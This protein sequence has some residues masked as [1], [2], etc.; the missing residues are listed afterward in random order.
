MTPL[1]WRN[2]F[3]PID[4]VSSPTSAPRHPAARSSSYIATC[5]ANV[6][7]LFRQTRRKVEIKRSLF[8]GCQDEMRVQLCVELYCALCVCLDIVKHITGG[9]ST[10]SAGDSGKSGD[11]ADSD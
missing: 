8:D 4:L 2:Q 3:Y 7:T 1:A 10:A 6:R 11:T 5:E 9:Q